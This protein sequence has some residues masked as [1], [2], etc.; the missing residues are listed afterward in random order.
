MRLGVS[1]A[2]SS[3][4]TGV[5]NQS[6]EALFPPRWSP[7]LHGLSPSPPAAALW[8]SCSFAHPAAQSASSLGPPAATLLQVLSAQLPLSASPTALDE[9]FFCNSLAVGLPYS[10]IFWLFWFFIFK[11]VVVLLLVVRGGKVYLP[12]PP[13]WPEVPKYP[14]SPFKQ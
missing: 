9:G 4:P 11:F 8:A 3:T 12:M 5:F 2:A 6:F 10:L 13:S 1:P 14:F 7:G